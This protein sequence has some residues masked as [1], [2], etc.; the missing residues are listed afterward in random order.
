[1]SKCLC[2]KRKSHGYRSY[3][4]SCKDE[5][6][7]KQIKFCNHCQKTK[8][9]NFFSK[10]RKRFMGLS[11][12]CNECLR[13]KKNI[14]KSFLQNLISDAKSHSIERRKRRQMNGIFNLDYEFIYNLWIQQNGLCSLTNI[15]M[16]HESHTDFKASIERIDNS[17]DYTKENVT[18]I[19]SELNTSNQW[20]KEKIRYLKDVDI[21]EI[22]PKIIEIQTRIKILPLKRE[23]ICRTCNIKPS[24]TM[25]KGFC[26]NCY[27]NRSINNILKNILAGCRKST[28]TRNGIKGRDKTE[29]TI[30]KDDMWQQ[31]QKQEGK[32]YYSGINMTIGLEKNWR[33]SIERLDVTQGYTKQNIVFMSRV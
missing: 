7:E 22:H 6:I 11:A 18:L 30:T 25:I 15:S 2:C 32:C 26:S 13:G 9:V 19:I 28:T 4:S 31:L 24:Q 3:C 14:L 27:K 1:M 17:T 29:C 5:F 12:H 20:T 21:T 10:H 16:S 33:I 23:S 8:P